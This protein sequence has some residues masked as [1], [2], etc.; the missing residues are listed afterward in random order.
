MEIFKC[1][2]SSLQSLFGSIIQVFD[3]QGAT[4][5]YLL[6]SGTC[7]DDFPFPCEDDV[8]FS[9]LEYVGY[10]YIYIYLYAHIHTYT[11]IYIY[12][13]MY[14]LFTYVYIYIRK[15]GG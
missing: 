12:T 13:Y 10:L 3:H 5:S 15:P 9:H 7:E 11:Y 6:R 2:G 4:N 1:F 14:I 8:P